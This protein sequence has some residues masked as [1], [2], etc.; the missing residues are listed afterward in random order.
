MFRETF[1]VGVLDS[2]WRPVKNDWSQDSKAYVRDSQEHFEHLMRENHSN[3]M[4]AKEEIKA[5]VLIHVI[6]WCKPLQD[7]KVIFFQLK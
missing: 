3:T 4:E 7:C 6:V 5:C 2:G 1:D